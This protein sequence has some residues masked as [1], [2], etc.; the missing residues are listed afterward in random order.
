MQKLSEEEYLHKALKIWGIDKEYIDERIKDRIGISAIEKL[1]QYYNSGIKNELIFNDEG[2]IDL[3]KIHFEKSMIKVNN[4]SKAYGWIIFPDLST[5]LLKIGLEQKDEEAGKK[6]RY[7]TLI[8]M[9]IARKMGIESASYYLTTNKINN[10]VKNELGYVY[11]PN[12]LKENEEFISGLDIG[13]D[14]VVRMELRGCTSNIDME[15]VEKGLEIYLKNRRFGK[16][17]INSV[18]K[19]FI[20]QCI[21]SKILENRDEANRNWGIII[22]NNENEEQQIQRNVKIAPMYDFEYNL[23]DK[24]TVEERTINENKDIDE[25]INH[26][27]KEEWFNEWINDKVLKLDMEEVYKSVLE[28]SK[29]T[30]PNQY[31]KEFKNKT[32][33]SINKIKN[34]YNKDIKSSE[35]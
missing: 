24:Y 29:I 7:A 21:V 16:E 5:G 1:Y 19:S 15:R 2:R 25:F 22:S 11:T 9:I 4:S 13:T 20:K 12:F 31:R 17:E 33:Q 26:Y 23:Q 10:K 18:R 3:E 6:S 35:R 34:I 28:T 32:E 30:I 14:S 8:S 27:S